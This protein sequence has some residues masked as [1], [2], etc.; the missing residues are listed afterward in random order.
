MVYSDMCV[1]LAQFREKWDVGATD[2]ELTR[3][4]KALA[5]HPARRDRHQLRIQA[6]PHGC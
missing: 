3:F 5:E 6:R 1:R 2:A 4:A